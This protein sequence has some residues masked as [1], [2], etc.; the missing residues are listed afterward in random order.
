MCI[1]LRI[2]QVSSLRDVIV[3]VM[4]MV[5]FFQVY[6][7]IHQLVDWLKGRKADMAIDGQAMEGH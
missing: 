2:L 5:N 7:L 4:R 1:V 3:G 6:A